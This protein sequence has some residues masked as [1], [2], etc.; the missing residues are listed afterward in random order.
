MNQEPCDLEGPSCMTCVIRRCDVYDFLGELSMATNRFGI[1][2]CMYGSRK[3]QLLDKAILGQGII[4]KA[5]QE[6]FCK[7]FF[8]FR[9]RM[10]GL[11]RYLDRLRFISRRPWIMAWSCRAG[12]YAFWGNPG[13]ETWG[14]NMLY[15]AWLSQVRGKVST[16]Y[17]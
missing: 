4:C 11:S 5:L 12:F 3:R 14:R 9:T 10:E 2:K 13:L 6:F 1:R 8:C 17:S 16:E 7:G 15:H